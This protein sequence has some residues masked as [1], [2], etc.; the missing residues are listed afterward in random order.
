MHLR[1]TLFVYFW[2]AAATMFVSAQSLCIAQTAAPSPA[3]AASPAAV[4][5]ASPSPAATPAASPAPAATPKPEG[6]LYDMGTDIDSI[7]DDA[8]AFY[9]FQGNVDGSAKVKQELRFGA[10]LWNDDAQLRIRIPIITRFPIS[11]NPFSGLG[12]IEL[13]YSYNARS[14]SLDHSLEVRFAFPTEANNVESD[15]TQLKLFYTDKWKWPGGALTYLNEFD[16]TVIHP[17]GASW[18]SYYEGKLTV[19]DY[20]ISKGLKLSAIYNYRLLFDS[21]STVKDA[22]GAVISGN[23]NDVAISV[24]DTWGVFDNALWRYKFEVNATAKF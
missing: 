24:Y 22:A 15:D 2:I 21:N 11:G 13:G 10:N 3:P 5:A 1:I 23:I 4:P 8:T 18:T 17:P 20:M 9:Y 12:N 14:S 16:Q 7:V 6:N 19:P